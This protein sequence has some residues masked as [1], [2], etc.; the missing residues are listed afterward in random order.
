MEAGYG[1]GSNLLIAATY[2]IIFA[3]FGYKIATAAV[4]KKNFVLHIF[5]TVTTEFL[6]MLCL[7]G[8]NLLISSKSGSTTTEA[9]GFSL[10]EAM[11]LSV[12]MSTDHEFPEAYGT[13][14]LACVFVVFALIFGMIALGTMFN[15]KLNI[16][17]TFA[18]TLISV[19]FTIIGTAL[20]CNK[21][22]CHFGTGSILAIVCAVFIFGTLIASAVVNNKKK[23]VTE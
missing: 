2:I 11:N 12:S 9:C 15:K 19:A 16:G 20:L 21:L 18:C 22:E 17:S 14:V 4:E 1:W 8:N 5:A 7:Y 6:L 10:L 13:I 23:P 3:Y